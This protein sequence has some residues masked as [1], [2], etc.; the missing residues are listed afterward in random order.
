M[1]AA[2]LAQGTT[3]LVN[4]SCEPEIVDLACFLNKMGAQIKF[5]GFVLFVYSLSK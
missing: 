2:C 1:M 3:T 5:G 4:A